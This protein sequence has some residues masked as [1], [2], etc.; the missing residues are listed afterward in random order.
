MGELCDNHA[1]P[2]GRI[3]CSTL[4][5]SDRG[6]DIVVFILLRGVPPVW[7]H[8]WHPAL[9]NLFGGLRYRLDWTVLRT[10]G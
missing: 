9:A 3:L 4:N 1:H 5:I 7:I 10:Q 2:R 6:H 8:D